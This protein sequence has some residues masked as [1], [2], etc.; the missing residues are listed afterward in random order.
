MVS[1][2]LILEAML[3]AAV[4]FTFVSLVG[5]MHYRITEAALEILTLGMVA[6]RIPLHEIEEVHRRGAFLH[7]NWS[8]PRFWNA[9]TIRRKR[10]VMKNIVISPDDPD[11]FAVR[12]NDAI[13]RV[14][15]GS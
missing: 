3:A 2:I 15:G 9:V 4:L 10:G 11:R 7:E 5:T 8:G 14:E 6:R 12:L 13:R 1:G